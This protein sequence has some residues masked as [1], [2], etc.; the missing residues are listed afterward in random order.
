MLLHL[1]IPMAKNHLHTPCEVSPHCHLHLDD[2][3]PSASSRQVKLCPQPWDLALLPKQMASNDHLP[4]NNCRVPT[5]R[6]T[7][8][9]LG[10]Y[11]AYSSRDLGGIPSPVLKLA[12]I[13]TRSS[14][15]KNLCIPQSTQNYT[16]DVIKLEILDLLYTPDNKHTIRGRGETLW[17]PEAWRA[18]NEAEAAEPT[19]REATA[20][21]LKGIRRESPA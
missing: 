19:K 15:C 20:K 2:K 4:Y 6:V 11:N 17:M 13:S 5:Q 1:A 3:E 16:E 8:S 14:T 12:P 9:K 7:V 10:E 21:A 18:A